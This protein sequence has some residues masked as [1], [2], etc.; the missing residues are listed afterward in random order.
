MP[1]S[2]WED[3]LVRAT[4]V[5]LQ[6]SGYGTRPGLNLDVQGLQAQ[7]YKVIKIYVFVYKSCGII[8]E[9]HVRDPPPPLECMCFKLSAST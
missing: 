4:L 3:W 5:T 6:L 2:F 1:V 9:F 7:Q 8:I